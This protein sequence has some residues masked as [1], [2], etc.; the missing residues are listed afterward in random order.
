MHAAGTAHEDLPVLRMIRESAEGVHLRAQQ[1]G[2]L[3]DGDL[4]GAHVQKSQ[5]VVGGGSVPGTSLPSWGVRV[6]A[7]DPTGFAARLRNGSPSV[8]CRV[9]PDHVLFDVR[10][11]GADEIPHL[12]RAILYA[13]EGDDLIED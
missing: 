8:F 3:L 13:L 4:E 5:S 1:L 12:A 6:G 9:E 2:G 11:V 7:P 10:T